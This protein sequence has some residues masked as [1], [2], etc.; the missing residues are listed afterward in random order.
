ML[1]RIVDVLGIL[2][3]L[4]GIYALMRKHQQS[5]STVRL[6]LTSLGSLIMN[7]GYLFMALAD[8]E[9]EAAVALQFE[10]LGNALFFYFFLTFL[11]SYLH[12]RIPWR[13]MMIWAATETLNVILFWGESLR[14][15]FFGK[16]RF[17]YHTGLDVYSV[18]LGDSLLYR[19]RYI[20]IG[21]MLICGVCF[22]A[23]RTV[24]IRLTSERRNLLRLAGAQSVLVLL[25]GL[26][27][28]VQ[29]EID[30]VPICSALAL[31]PVVISMLTDGFFGV[32][33][34]GHEWVF[35]QMENAYIITDSLYG[36]LDANP[37]AKELF[38][39]LKK[40]GLNKPIPD[41][42]RKI[43]DF[44]AEQFRLSDRIY[45]KKVTE[46]QHQGQTVGYGL[47][48]E[49]VSEQL[50][51]LNLLNDYNDRLQT[52]VSEKTRHIQ[53]VQNSIITGMASVVESRD[54]STGG[55]INRT[56]MVVRIF[57]E[58]LKE[59]ED[60]LHLD[61]RF[62]MNVAKAAPMHDIGKIAIADTVL[63]KPGIFTQEEY[64]I[65]KRHPSE[66]ARIL[67]NILREVDDEE[68]VNI[69]LNVA[70]YHHEKWDGTGYPTHRSGEDIPV[71]A[72]IMALADVFDA[73]VSERC[74]KEAFPFET[75]FDMME[76]SL[77]TQ[78]DPVLGKVFLECR[79]DLIQLYTEMEQN[80]QTA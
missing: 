52:E 12:L 13:A 55:H 64:E 60:T 21:I 71:E 68:F 8:T 80:E 70:H 28:F 22:V 31:L 29:P 76:A 78:F 47:L 1:I 2:I 40:L 42:I 74:Y 45:S 69:A 7:S 15:L 19:L 27:L 63:R 32:T 59:K 36:Y 66:G 75:A 43:F 51:Y 79:D 65:M 58:K 5:E 14:G 72:R 53:K 57:A 9:S 3:P 35:R 30:L 18:Q 25:I 17:T 24:L 38:P 49:D 62:L 11:L 48:L 33:D 61:A 46:L 34:S 37:Q 67:K 16:I 20:A 23:G 56:S 4:A 44:S 26:Q 10:F 54:N 73:L 77:G 39:E 50:K 6:M 41:T